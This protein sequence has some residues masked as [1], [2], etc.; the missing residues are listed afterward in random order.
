[1]DGAPQ[2]WWQWAFMYPTLVIALIGA[3]PQYSQWIEA[4]LIGIPINENIKGAQEQETAW[5][6]NIDCLQ[7]IDHIK[8][9]SKTNY[10][11]DLVSCPTG[12]ILV[13]VTPLQNPDQHVSRWIVTKDLF[14]QLAGSWFSTGAWAQGAAGTPPGGAV[15][16][17]IVDTRKD[18]SVVT[19]RIQLSD[20]S[21][22][23]ETI[24]AF[25]GRHVGRKPAPCSK[26]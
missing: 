15:Q 12:D 24:D 25:T 18:G 4:K 21:C 22:V 1:M 8:P 3:V 26:F 14:T 7:G 10:G 6:S 20:N 9:N 13:T 23:G 5:E 11:I 16:Q 17:R 2:R 19:Q